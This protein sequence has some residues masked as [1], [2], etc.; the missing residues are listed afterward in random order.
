MH[1]S[2]AYWL[3]IL[4]GSF[5]VVQAAIAYASGR[6]TDA[7][8]D[9]R[10]LVETLQGENESR[11]KEIHDLNERLDFEVEKR[12]AAELDRDECLG[13]LARERRIVEMTQ[14][15]A[16]TAISERDTAVATKDEVQ[17]QLRA[18]HEEIDSLHRIIA[19]LD[20]EHVSP[21]R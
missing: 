15:A 9:L 1:L 21:Q 7:S 18:A 13:A 11:K 14:Y 4:A 12:Q 10:T 19:A 16:D 17:T 6:K 2:P 5:L 8:A 20:P 3:A